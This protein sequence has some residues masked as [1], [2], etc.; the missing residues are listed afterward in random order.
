MKKANVLITGWIACFIL[1]FS[2]VS[3]QTADSC[4]AKA[5]AEVA[6]GQSFKYTVTTSTQGEIISTD[7]GKFELIN[8]PSIGTS[9]SITMVNGQVEQKTTYTYTYYLSGNKEGSHAIPGVTLSFDG[10]LVKSN[11]VVVNVVKASKYQQPQEEP[12]QADN[13]FHF[14]MP[15]WFGSQQPQQNTPQDRSKSKVEIDDKVSKDDMFLKASV[16][17][18]DAYQGEAVV[19]THKLYVKQNVN[20]YSIERASFGQTESFWLDGLQLSARD[21]TST[22]TINGKTYN[23]YLVKQTAAY[24][25]KTGKL[26]IPKLN[27]VLSI[28]VP[29]T[30]KDPFWGTYNTYKNKDV[31]LSSNEVTIKVKPLPAAK[32]TTTEIVGNFSISSTVNKTTVRVNEPITLTITVSGNGNL[33]HIIAD[34]LNNNFPADCDV[35]F[36]RITGAIGSK[37]NIV[38][39][40]KTFKY[41]IIP[42]SEG[43]YIIP[44]A[45]Y[46]Y[47]NYDTQS[48]K[49]ISSQDYQIEV[50]PGK[51]KNNDTDNGEEPLPV[52]KKQ[53]KVKSY[54]I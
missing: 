38:T 29:A 3:A 27:V 32:G 10:K 47:Y 21:Q 20:G 18:Y 22:E 6:V 4:F 25:T 34:D 37:A 7:F 42:R 39:G 19:V 35:T 31:E 17:Q 12:Q 11:Y 53:T 28:R 33:H 36:P 2:I 16:S 40:S 43:T 52:E 15:Q 44:G 13:W 23:V 46:T 5:P 14:D 41:V 9:T 30:V 48:Y 8:G 45:T 54:K 1:L 51:S 24:P 26:V 50:V 49:T